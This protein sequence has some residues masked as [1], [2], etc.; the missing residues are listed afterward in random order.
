MSAYQP[1]W[2]KRTSKLNSEA[3]NLWI[4]VLGSNNR[5]A[6]ASMPYWLTLQASLLASVKQDDGTDASLDWSIRALPIFLR[7]E[8]DN[9]HIRERECDE[10][11]QL[12]SFPLCLCI[13]L[14]FVMDL[15]WHRGCTLPLRIFNILH[16]WLKR[17][18]L[19]LQTPGQLKWLMFHSPP[20][21]LWV[22]RG[23][24]IIAHTIR[25]S[26]SEWSQT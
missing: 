13:S 23:L 7:G 14:K 11:L 6:L 22:E 19:N 12:F 8:A 3:S 25:W 1:W 18:S 16:Y 26:S 4:L 10:I 17:E 20:I 24:W 9:F 2:I 5:D 15:I 21:I